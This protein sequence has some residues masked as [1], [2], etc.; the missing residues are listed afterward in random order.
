MLYF[1]LTYNKGLYTDRPFRERTDIQI[2]GDTLIDVFERMRKFV[3]PSEIRWNQD[4][5]ELQLREDVGFNVLRTWY[6]EEI[7]PLYFT[8]YRR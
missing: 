8:L 4:M 3:K 6:W 7:K 1:E 2:C 5:L